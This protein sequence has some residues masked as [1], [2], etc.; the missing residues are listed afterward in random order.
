MSYSNLY[1][2]S[3]LIHLLLSLSDTWTAFLSTLSSKM[4]PPVGLLTKARV[5]KHCCFFSWSLK[6]LHSREPRKNWSCSMHSPWHLPLSVPAGGLPA[7]THIHSSPL[8]RARIPQEL[9]KAN[10]AFGSA[11][12]AGAT[13]S[14]SQE[15]ICHKVTPTPTSNFCPGNKSTS[16]SC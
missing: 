2:S 15:T 12:P 5:K 16:I 3:H 4:E 7:V 9:C 13:L 10:K 14:D 6:K 11:V 1:C 8:E